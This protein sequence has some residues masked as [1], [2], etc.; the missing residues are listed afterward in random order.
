VFELLGVVK[1]PNE[2]SF[3]TALG[4]KRMSTLARLSRAFPSP[5]RATSRIEVAKWCSEVFW[6]PVYGI[7]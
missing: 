1:F 6:T 4:A 3:D 5:G 2:L 7:S